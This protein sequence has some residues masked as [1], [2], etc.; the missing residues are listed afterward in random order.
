MELRAARFPRRLELRDTL[1]Q[2][3]DPLE[4]RLDD[5][6]VCLQA[7]G[8]GLERARQVDQMLIRAHTQHLYGITAYCAAFANRT[9]PIA[10]SQRMRIVFVCQA[11]TGTD[12]AVGGSVGASTS[13]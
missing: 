12:A 1:F 3:H 10:H 8:R 2:L 13:S 7:T 9:Q 4:M 6:I 11:E 5:D